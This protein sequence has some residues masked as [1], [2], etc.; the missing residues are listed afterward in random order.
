MCQTALVD[1]INTPRYIS[2][3]T[4]YRVLTSCVVITLTKV[5]LSLWKQLGVT[6]PFH[7]HSAVIYNRIFERMHFEFR[8]VDFSCATDNENNN[9]N[10]N[11]TAE[12]ASDENPKRI[13]AEHESNLPPAVS[14]HRTGPV[15]TSGSAFKRPP[16]SSHNSSGLADLRRKSSSTSVSQRGGAC[17]LSHELTCR[18]KV[19]RL[20][21]ACWWC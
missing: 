18:W 11:N 9:N 13:F 21:V 10:N 14:P 19:T 1:N 12:D 4:Y 15:D 3:E 6:E 16:S 5:A 8:D 7:R 2:G 20:A 17:R